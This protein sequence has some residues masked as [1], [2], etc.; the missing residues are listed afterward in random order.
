MDKYVLR[1]HGVSSE[2]MNFALGSF[3]R[4]LSDTSTLY[5]T[6]YAAHLCFYTQFL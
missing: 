2:I 1:I 6:S 5:S 4:D 3:E